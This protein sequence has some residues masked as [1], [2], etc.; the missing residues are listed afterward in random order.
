MVGAMMAAIEPSL[1]P[2]P[3]GAKSARNPAVTPMAFAFID[4]MR[5]EMLGVILVE[6]SATP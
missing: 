5:F 2:I 6:D 1:T 3:P 4:D